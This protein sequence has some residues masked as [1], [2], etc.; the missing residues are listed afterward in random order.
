MST[1][2]NTRR[3]SP[4]REQAHAAKHSVPPPRLALRW[5]SEVAA[6][7]GVS[8]DYVTKQ[9]LAAELPMVRRGSLRLVAVHAL[10]AWLIDNAELVL[11]GR[12]D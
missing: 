8:V 9:G 7:L 12:D 4:V 5:P 3:P 2:A 1:T 11:D 6:T 10:D